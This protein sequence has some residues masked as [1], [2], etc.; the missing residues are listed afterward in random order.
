MKITGGKDHECA[1]LRLPLF[2]D[3]NAGTCAGLAEIG[4]D[5]IIVRSPDNAHQREGVRAANTPT[6]ALRSVLAQLRDPEQR[7]ILLRR[8][9]A[10]LRPNRT[11]RDR[12][13]IGTDAGDN[14][15]DNTLFNAIPVDVLERLRS[16]NPGAPP[17]YRDPRKAKPP[18]RAAS[19]APLAHHRTWSRRT[20]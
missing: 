11:T 8:Q 4:V 12:N 1:E 9:A 15:F 2:I 18:S 5:T 14:V 19:R 3:D 6:D 17:R 20:N 10:L 16:D 13:D 7:S